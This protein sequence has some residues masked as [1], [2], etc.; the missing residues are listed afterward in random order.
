M[1][2]LGLDMGKERDVG[3]MGRMDGPTL[4]DDVLCGI[5][6]ERDLGRSLENLLVNVFIV[7]DVGVFLGVGFIDEGVGNALASEG[8]DGEGIVEEGGGGVEGS[9]AVWV[10]GMMGCVVGVVVVEVFVGSVRSEEEGGV[11]GGVGLV[12]WVLRKR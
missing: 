9:F 5:D 11:E 1:I 2:K 7:R 10:G 3:G 8:T 6:P 4:V 12:D